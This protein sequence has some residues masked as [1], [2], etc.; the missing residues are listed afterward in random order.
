M[1]LPLVWL[2]AC[3]HSEIG[4]GGRV[5]TAGLRA[6]KLPV[7]VEACVTGVA[8]YYDPG[9]GSLVVQDDAGAIKFDKVERGQ[10]Q[11]G[12]RVEVCGVTR[13]LQS[14]MSLALPIVKSLGA[15]DLPVARR[16]SSKEWIEGRVDWQWIEVEGM[17]NAVTLN[18]FGIMTMY[19]V[20]DGRRVGVKIDGTE[21]HPSVD[22][23]MGARVRARGVA[24]RISSSSGNEDLLLLS[25]DLRF[26]TEAAPQA[27][28]ASLPVVTVADA[29]KMAR[30]LPER[31]VRLR[32]SIVAKGDDARQWFRDATG[33]LRLVLP[34][35][36]LPESEDSE[37]V[38][39]PVRTGV[40]ATVLEGP[41]STRS[42]APAA[43]GV[44]TSV[45][46][47]HALAA[48]EALRSLPVKFQ[49]VVT[50]RQNNGV[51]FVEDRTGGTYLEY[52]GPREGVFAAG[53][54]VEITGV[55]G[56]GDF[57]PI[58]RSGDVRRLGRGTM[59]KPRP[60]SLDAL[61]TGR[62]DSNWVEAEGYVAAV[63][64]SGATLE[65]TMVEGVHTFVAY[66][67]D[68]G[69][70]ANRLLDSRVRLEGVCTTRMNE[71]RQLIGIALLTPGWRY[72]AILNPGI[73]NAADIPQTRI[74]D[75][76]RYSPEEQHRVRIR[77]ALTLIDPNG[78]AYV[79]DPTAGLR[80]EGTLPGDLQP[81]DEVEAIGLPAPGPFSPVLEHAEVRRLGR[82]AQVRAPGTNAEDALAGGCDSQLARI[83]A[84]VV[85]H[86]STF[87]DQRL[88]M[89]AGDVLFNAHLPYERKAMVWP[90]DGALL[91]LTGVC[92]VRVEVKGQVVPAAFELYL[93]SSSDIQ[94]LRG[95]PWLDRRRA[96]QALGAMAALILCSAVWIQL[97][98]KR[99]RRQTSIIRAQLD[100]EAGLREAAEAASRA[101][102]EFV[103][104]MSHEI[105]TPMNGVVGMTEL[106]LDTEIT[107]EQREYLNMMRNSA[108]ALLT[109]VND[110]LDFSKIEAGKLD[111]E[112]AGF[113]P[114]E[115]LDRIMKDFGLR[116]AQKDI[117]LA[118]EVTSAVPPSVMGDAS[119]LRQILNNLL[120]NALKFTE[121]GEIVVTADL[122]S[123]DGDTLLL[124]FTVRDTGIGIPAEKIESIFEAFSQG[125]GSTTRQYGGTGL[126]LTV[127]LRLVKMMGGRMWVESEPG[128]GSCFHFTAR[129]GATEPARSAEPAPP[130]LPRNARVLV[131]DDNDT[132]RRILRDALGKLG[133]DAKAA[134]SANAAIGLM[135]ELA[136]AGSPVTLLV[137]DAHMPG[138]DGFSLAEQVK[139]DPK[140]AQAAIV[141]LISADHRGDRARCRAMGI[142]EYLAKPV[143][144]LELREAV[145]TRLGRKAAESA[146]RGAAARHAIRER[147]AGL[148][149]K[150]LV[151]ED[152]PVNQMVV[153]TMIERRG[154]TVVL[155][156][157]GREALE[158][159][160]ENS[161]DLILMDIQ[162]PEMDGFEASAAIRESERGTGRHQP[163]VAMTAHA[164]KGD[165]QRCL[166]AG[167]DGY[168]A[169]PIRGEDLYAMLD[170]FPER[171]A[172]EELPS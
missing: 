105:R 119:R 83:E 71:H 131:V 148:R 46:Q 82:A 150:I 115:T 38:G 15:A 103:A 13:R 163:I 132:S 134:A 53:D 130:L 166:N 140:L 92:E 144:E 162:M 58:V 65:L 77:G 159:L 75:L 94:V 64:E 33:E 128:Q 96:F 136:D 62:E 93:R 122:D 76:L 56:P 161:F 107:T 126:G 112:C 133:I 37:I 25:P 170:A 35:W 120:G 141:M 129:L 18:R 87:A 85:D 32:G 36:R 118:C 40:G 5:S 80:V 109:V 61:L 124:H 11:Y 135:R 99:V 16:A 123:R 104:N 168:L 157:N 60:E 55:T 79:Q 160:R 42:E 125:D 74:S 138:T 137:A 47:V 54:L 169:K 116:A 41:L 111:L 26:V 165:E 91:R 63:R 142:P 14:G 72:V 110:V 102:S 156:N 44:L 49:A 68:P 6:G 30:L 51:T 167:M 143:S 39:F 171:L 50:Y 2:G 164:M 57:A 78:A 70:L 97:L 139:A 48:N 88:V 22:N 90:D 155:A 149:Q 154:H 17:A 158:A 69:G 146:A 98:R 121:H 43:H 10:A 73:A 101:K 1:A 12:Q 19:L 27:P 45:R 114:T 66:L 147:P 28:L 153:V 34:E 145:F 7:A 59:P 24:R 113:A 8:T 117:E 29:A 9:A 100:K 95:V 152:N 86:L 106:L 3:S 52:D 89:Q 67:A 84:T 4:P 20:V 108:D 127:S 81:G 172:P 151:V 21:A 31:R 23:L